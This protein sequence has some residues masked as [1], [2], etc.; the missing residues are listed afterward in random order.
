MAVSYSNCIQHPKGLSG[1]FTT[2]DLLFILDLQCI[3]GSV[4]LCPCYSLVGAK[5][6]FPL[7]FI[8]ISLKLTV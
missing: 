2:A 5:W 8:R 1:Y 7:V 3:R 6:H 4:F